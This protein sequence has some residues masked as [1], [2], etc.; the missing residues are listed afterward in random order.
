MKPIEQV[1]ER[2]PVYPPVG[3]TARLLVATGLAALAAMAALPGRAQPGAPDAQEPQDAPLVIDLGETVPLSKTDSAGNPRRPAAAPARAQ[4]PRS[5]SG[6]S[7][8]AATVGAAPGESAD[9]A[10]AAPARSLASMQSAVPAV[11]VATPA[12]TSA[13]TPAAGAVGDRIERVVYNRRPVRVALPLQR[14]RL[15]T[16]AGPV[17]LHVPTGIESLVRLQI[18]GRSVYA[19]ALA[20]FGPLRVLAEDLERDGLQIP[21]DLV[22]DRSSTEAGAEID[23]HPGALSATRAGSADAAPRS[24][25]A[26]ADPDLAEPGLDMVALTRHAARMLYAPTRLMPADPAVRQVALDLHP[27]A[28]LYR[29][30]RLRTTP[31]GA[32]RS[33]PLYVTAVR[34]TNLEDRPVELQ[35]H[36][37][38]GQWLAATPQHGRLGPAG[39]DTD[40]TAV[41]LVCAQPFA[42]CR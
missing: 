21:L 10:P 4:A 14:E 2:H 13:P 1:P 34:F 12:P 41:Y 15:I 31:M 3:R 27:V 19:T 40:T 39:T 8:G 42:S 35:M 30:R 25:A 26:Q 29:G 28:G 5:A 24:N 37:L 22:A 7:V 36:E 6:A 11:V 9:P 18:V 33:G 20:T 16:F 17:A 23:I 32:W 38:R